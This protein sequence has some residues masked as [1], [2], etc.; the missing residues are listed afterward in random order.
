MDIHKEEFSIF[1]SST[2]SKALHPDN[3]PQRFT[4]ELPYSIILTDE[5]KVA[6]QTI[7]MPVMHTSPELKLK[8]I[9][10]INGD[11]Q[12]ERIFLFPKFI[13]NETQEL[14]NLINVQLT[15]MYLDAI[16]FKIHPS[17][18]H[19][20]INIAKNYAIHLDEHTALFFGYNL[21]K[22]SLGITITSSSRLSSKNRPK[23]PI[24]IIKLKHIA[25]KTNIIDYSI[26]GERLEQILD[27]VYPQKSQ[28]YIQ[29][30]QPNYV[31]VNKHTLSNISIILTSQSI[32]D[33]YNYINPHEVETVVKLHFYRYKSRLQLHDK[34]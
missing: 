30:K 11:H 33:S 3:T 18:N 19:L 20:V 5:W 8:V 1:A 7:S 27:I 12:E 34:Q 28:Q 15:H 29:I 13:F 17:T 24:K 23:V 25:V 9:R 6:L 14:I 4:F 31:Y 10:T 16:F 2:H 21:Q 32:N 22:A 26:Y